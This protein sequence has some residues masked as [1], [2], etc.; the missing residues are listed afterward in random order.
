[1]ATRRTNAP[2]KRPNAKAFGEGASVPRPKPFE[3]AAK[4]PHAETE[5][6]EIDLVAEFS[7]ALAQQE[8]LD[9]ESQIFIVEQFQHAVQEANE[10][11]DS[12]P[13]DRAEWIHVIELLQQSGEL[14]E[15]ETNT[16]IRQLDAALRPLEGREARL[17]LEFNR[18]L[19]GS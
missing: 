10:D 14:A 9:K 13:P 19:D 8:G 5:P 12:K 7:A 11:P 6:L 4:V 3:N 1:M 17:A 2:R 15:D 18:R 16:L